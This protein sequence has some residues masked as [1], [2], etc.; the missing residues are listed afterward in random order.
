MTASLRLSVP[1]LDDPAERAV[2]FD[3][4]AS[5]MEEDG[6]DAFN[7]QTRLDLA[8]G[9]RSPVVATASGGAAEGRVVAAAVLGRGELDLVVDPLFRGLGFGEAVLDGLLATA[10]GP[11]TAWAHGGHPAAARLAERFG[12]EPVRR[13]LRLT[14]PVP[15]A[16]STPAGPPSP[17]S[18]SSLR[19]GTDEEEWVRLN[20]RVFAGHPEQGSL[21]LD[22]LHDRMAEP[23]FDAE[24]V[25]VLR[26]AE[27]RMAGF[28]WLKVEEGAGEIYVLG[29]DPELAGRGFGRALLLAGM[30]RLAERGVSRVD[31]YV[32]GDNDAALGLY[33]SAG[34]VD[35][36]VDVQYRREVGL[37][38]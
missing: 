38:M 12:F 11:L 37:Q 3:V 25:L 2:F 19:P 10:A 26:D 22:D 32:E 20:A 9:R 7:E 13:L 6:A 14:A 31:L 15:D 21:T 5:G 17:Y 16:P 35:R 30:S 1:D 34:F 23:W 8:A 29:V 28:D 33:R 24:D 18:L 27:G 4:A 36:T